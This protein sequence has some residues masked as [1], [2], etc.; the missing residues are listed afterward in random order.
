MQ[1][2][3][4]QLTA[5]MHVLYPS[6]CGCPDRNRLWQGDRVWTMRY[7]MRFYSMADRVSQP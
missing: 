4:A 3:K 1:S 5:C 7:R 6:Q 2:H